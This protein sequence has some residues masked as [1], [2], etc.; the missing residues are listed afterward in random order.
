[1]LFLLLFWVYCNRGAATRS[2]K[3]GIFKS[4][5]SPVPQV[6]KPQRTEDLRLFLLKHNLLVIS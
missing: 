4:S 2:P 6:D 5:D 1:M 3:Q